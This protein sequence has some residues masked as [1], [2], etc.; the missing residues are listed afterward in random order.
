MSKYFLLDICKLRVLVVFV[1]SRQVFSKVNVQIKTQKGEKVMKG[2][3]IPLCG[4]FFKLKLKT[5]MSN[6]TQ[7]SHLLMYCIKTFIV[8]EHFT[9]KKIKIYTSSCIE[10]VQVLVSVFSSFF[11]FGEDNTLFRSA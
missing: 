1:P 11:D 2:H 3:T 4:F 5:I 8:K 9:L 6:L 10:T 7:T